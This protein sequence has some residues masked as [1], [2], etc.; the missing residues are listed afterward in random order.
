MNIK[1]KKIKNDPL[2]NT[3][4]KNIKHN[5]AKYRKY[6]F[7]KEEL[8]KHTVN[9]VQKINLRLTAVNNTKFVENKFLNFKFAL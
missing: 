7:L 3:D 9:E 5:K 2:R 4:N 6:S 8:R 1:I